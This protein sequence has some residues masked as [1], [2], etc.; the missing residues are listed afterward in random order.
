EGAYKSR[1][2]DFESLSKDE[3]KRSQANYRG[4]I[5]RVLHGQEVAAS[6]ATDPAMLSL[7]DKDSERKLDSLPKLYLDAK[8]WPKFTPPV[9]GKK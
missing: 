7:L 8:T 5:F 3:R 1:T 2:D 6:V 9:S 4:A